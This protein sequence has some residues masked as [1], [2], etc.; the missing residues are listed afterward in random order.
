MSRELPQRPNLEYLRKQAKEL[1]RT[2]GGGKLAD[3]QHTLA[4]EYGFA[5]WAQLKSHVE[6]LHLTPAEALR[7]AVCACN[8]RLVRELLDRHPELRAKIDDPLPNYGFGRGR[9]HTQAN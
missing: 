6:L 9:R 4:N 8:P 2:A 3:A 1:L 5:T 7:T